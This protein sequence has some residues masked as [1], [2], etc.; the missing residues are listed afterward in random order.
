[1]RLIFVAVSVYENILTTKLSQITVYHFTR[2]TSG[3]RRFTS[4]RVTSILNENPTLLPKGV[5]S[6][7]RLIFMIITPRAHARSGVK[8]SVLSVSLSVCQSVSDSTKIEIS[9]HRPYPHK[10]SKWSQTIANSKKLLY[11]YLTEVKSLRFAV[12]R[13]FP[14]FHNYS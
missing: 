7:N 12:F 8:Q 1:M 14:T 9:P 5:D 13:L 4:Q 3:F 10:P 2:R 6:Y 11:V